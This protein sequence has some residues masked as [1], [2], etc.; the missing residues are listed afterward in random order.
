[1]ANTPKPATPRTTAPKA[2]PFGLRGQTNLPAQRQGTPTLTGAYRR[3]A[4]DLRRQSVAP[5]R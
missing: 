4:A 1:M 3:A 5:K 2:P